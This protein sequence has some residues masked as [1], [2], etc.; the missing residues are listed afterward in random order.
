MTRIAEWSL[1]MVNCIYLHLKYLPSY[2]WHCSFSLQS[3]SLWQLSYVHLSFCS[4]ANLWI[5]NVELS[6]FTEMT[7][8]NIS[9]ELIYT[10][11]SCDSP[12]LTVNRLTDRIN[13]DCLTLTSTRL[14]ESRLD[15]FSFKQ[16]FWA[17]KWGDIRMPLKISGGSSGNNVPSR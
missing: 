11:Y 2:F 7:I 3:L 15:S 9:S 6:T 4:S 8:W 10:W 1:K 12:R 14:S 17:S 5:F 13:F 16:I